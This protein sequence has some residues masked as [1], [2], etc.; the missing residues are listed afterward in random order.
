MWPE[1][2]SVSIANLAKNITTVSEMSNFSY[3]FTFL[4]RTAQ[5]DTRTNIQ[6]SYCLTST[7]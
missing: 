5:S 4:A 2:S 1:S 6:L 3:G 7:V